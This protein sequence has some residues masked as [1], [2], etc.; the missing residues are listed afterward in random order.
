MKKILLS[1]ALAGISYFTHAQAGIDH[2]AYG[3]KGGLNL[4]NVKGKDVEGTSTLLGFH[5]GVQA[6]LP[7]AAGFSLQPELFY[8]SEGAKMKV[9]MPGDGDEIIEATAKTHLNYLNLPV[10][11]QYQHASG[12]FAVTGPQIGYLLSAKVKMNGASE[13]VKESF[14]KINFGWTLGVGY[15][16]PA[17]S[18]GIDVRYNFGLAKL[19]KG[20]DGEAAGKAYSRTLQAGVFYRF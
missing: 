7:L 6:N 15:V 19:A 4:A 10:L 14:N 20:V 13:D 8:S 18:I 3:V 11:L 12:A 5:G 16:I 1:A 2:I 17:T 9:Q